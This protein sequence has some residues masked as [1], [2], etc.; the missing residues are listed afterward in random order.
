MRNRIDV[1]KTIDD[2]LIPYADC[3]AW[4]DY[5]SAGSPCY[6]PYDFSSTAEEEEAAYTLAAVQLEMRKNNSRHTVLAEKV[7]KQT[8]NDYVTY[9]WLR[10]AV[11]RLL[12]G[13]TYDE[14]LSMSRLSKAVKA[15]MQTKGLTEIHS[16]ADVLS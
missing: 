4:E 5:G 10:D 3:I 9:P 7:A 2:V 1:G 15:G 12:A 14:L 16:I 11:T 6:D 8:G 13:S